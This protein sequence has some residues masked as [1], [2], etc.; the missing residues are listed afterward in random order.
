MEKEYVQERLKNYAFSVED[1]HEMRERELFKSGQ[2][3][4]NNSDS[5]APDD[6]ETKIAKDEIADQDKDAEMVGQFDDLGLAEEDFH[7][8]TENELLK[9]TNDH[10]APYKFWGWV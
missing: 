5:S 4:T 3:K 2:A 10:L 6:T 9:E 8:T 1:F 7:G